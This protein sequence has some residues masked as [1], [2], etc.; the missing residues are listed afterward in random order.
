MASHFDAVSESAA[1]DAVQPAEQDAWFVAQT[2]PRQEDRAEANL[3][4]LGIEIFLPRTREPRT[5]RSRGARIAPFFP[6]YLFVRCDIAARLHQI[7]YTRG[8][9]RMLGN[10][11]GPLPIDNSII[12]SIRQ[13]IGEDGLIRI[14]SSFKSGDAVRVTAGPLEDFNGVFQR[15]RHP[16]ERVEILLKTVNGSFRVLVDCDQLEAY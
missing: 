6:S 12:E 15:Y 2:K 13:R 8:V 1:Q 9:H 4:T 3:R 16:S 10:G 14:G 11:G 5:R 7:T